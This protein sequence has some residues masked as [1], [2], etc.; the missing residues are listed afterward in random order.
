[1]RPHPRHQH[2]PPIAVVSGMVNVL[3]AGGE[4]QSAPHLCR[5]VTLD[6]IFAAVPESTV[7]DEK[8]IATIGQI[9]LMIFSNRVAYDGYAGAIS[10]TAPNCT[11]H[12]ESRF[13]RLVY[14]RVGK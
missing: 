6:N 2:R 12:A 4:I 5:I 10:P 8:T 13:D 7:A 1:M 9:D 11:L 14:F 3:Q